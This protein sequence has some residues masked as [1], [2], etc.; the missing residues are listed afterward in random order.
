[1][2]LWTLSLSPLSFPSQFF[3]MFP[4]VC[5]HVKRRLEPFNH[6]KGS[7]KRSHPGLSYRM[8]AESWQTPKSSSALSSTLTLLAFSLAL[9]HLLMSPVPQDGGVCL[10]DHLLGLCEALVRFLRTTEA[11]L[12]G[13]CPNTL[14][15]SCLSTVVRGLILF[16]PQQRYF[17]ISK[18]VKYLKSLSL[19]VLK[20]TA[21]CCPTV[22]S[23]CLAWNH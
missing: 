11:N 23:S 8:T 21:S 14:P 20:P 7:G 3:I 22:C 18:A 13:F 5:S 4:V 10:R 17:K 9:T 15:F 6:T 2:S 19:W 12:S 16:Q 1:M